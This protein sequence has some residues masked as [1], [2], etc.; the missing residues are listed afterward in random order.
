MQAALVHSDGM[1]TRN[2]NEP[3]AF[4]ITGLALLGCADY[5]NGLMMLVEA[6]NV[7]QEGGM[8]IRFVLNERMC[9][10]VFARVCEKLGL[11]Q[12]AEE[13]RKHYEAETLDVPAIRTLIE[14][15]KIGLVKLEMGAAA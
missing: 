14:A 10:G 6:F 15:L 2:R 5:V 11:K 12:H 7:S 4:V 9:L 3:V 1:L 13:F 8:K